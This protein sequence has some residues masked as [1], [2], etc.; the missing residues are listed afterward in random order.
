MAY[1]DKVVDHF[2]RRFVSTPV[3]PKDRAVLVD[4]LVKRGS[5]SFSEE[6]LRELLY[7]VWSLPAYQLG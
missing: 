7:L 4:F 2:L 6:A 5:P 3:P 1:S